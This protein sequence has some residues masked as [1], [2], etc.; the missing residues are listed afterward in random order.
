MGDL[1]AADKLTSKLAEIESRLNERLRQIQK[2]GPQNHSPKEWLMILGEEVG[3]VNR[4]ALEAH[5]GSEWDRHKHLQEYR[6]ELIQVAAVAI[7][8]IESF[9][10]NEGKVPPP[11]EKD[12]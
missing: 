10:R 12:L 11:N 9:D 6:R 8:M 3:E 5:F 4:A 7:S 1:V 2:F